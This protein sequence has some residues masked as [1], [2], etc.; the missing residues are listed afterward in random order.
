[1]KKFAQAAAFAWILI[2]ISAHAQPQSWTL[3]NGIIRKIVDFTPEHGL[4]VASWSDLTSGFDFVSPEFIH[5]GYNEFEF[6]ADGKSVSGKSAD[7]TLSGN[8]QERSADGTQHLDLTFSARHAL[9]TV[10]V[11]YELGANQPAIRQYLSITNTGAAPVVLHHLTVAAAA[12]APG[13]EHDLIAFGGYGEQPREIYFTGR[14]NDVAV[15]LENAKT[16]IGFAI[17][18]EVPGYMKRVEL[19]QIGWTQWAPAFAA[20]YDTDLFPFERTLAP[21]ETFTSAAVS[22]LFYK[23]GTAADP[24]WRIPE[25]VRDRISHLHENAAPDWV[26]NTWEP[27]RK[28]INA[29]LLNEVIP[30]AA[31]DGFTLLTLDD[32]W[33]LRYGDND[34]DTKR[35]PA[36]LD[37]VFAQADALGLR[38]GLWAPLALIDIKAHDFLAH[39]EWACREPDGSPRISNGGSGVVM[40]LASPYKFAAI[41]RIS[42]LVQRYKLRYIKLDLT[43][44]FNTYG[45]QPGCF[46]KREE[47]KTPQESNERIYEA[48]DLIA[49]T[50]HQRFPSLLIDYSFELWGEKHLIDYGLL[51]FA[52]L[53]WISNIGDQTAEAAGPLQVR[54]LLYQRAMAIP[55]ETLL[56]GNLQAET[57]PWQEHLATAMASGPLFLGDLRKQSDA[58]SQHIH[59]WIARY[60][61]LRNAVSLTDS[62]FPLGSWQ[63]PRIDQWDGYARLARS[64]EGLIVL[65]RNDSTTASAKL[66]I[67]G[68]PDGAFSFTSWTNGEARDVRGSEVRDTITVPF[69]GAGRVD[70]IE[71]RRR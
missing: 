2:S 17:L 40:S 57:P 51:R 26:Y 36:G 60:T 46:E 22:V 67:P 23:R 50:L 20:M 48:L 6:T 55:V 19:G 4:E 39:P 70:V 47:Y 68:F 45:E 15:L 38:R 8:H 58:D 43:T 31:A 54:T 33:E 29:G 21:R 25:Y 12:L 66:S 71:V 13:S 63:Q 65:F 69:S 7:V 1:M 52:D 18:S 3:D 9:L 10:T 14:V 62:F 56:I 34:V 41:E 11:H 64:G 24:H 42:T 37:P 53:D 35:F 30:K 49:S 27:F 5:R 44:V 16:G 32:G 59:E 61:R 28:D